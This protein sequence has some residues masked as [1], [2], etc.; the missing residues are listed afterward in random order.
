MHAAQKAVI[1]SLSD[2]TRV[3]PAAAAVDSLSGAAVVASSSSSSFVP[4][5]FA[6]DAR[7][8]KP[9]E[10]DRCLR[11]PALF[12]SGAFAL[13]LEWMAAMESSDRTDEPAPLWRLGLVIPK[14]Y[15]ASAVARNTIKRRWRDAFR[16]GRAAWATEFGSADV[17]VRL[18]APLMPKPAKAAGRGASRA[19]AVPMPPARVR[20]RDRFDA[21]AMLGGFVDRVRSRGG[22]PAHVVSSTVPS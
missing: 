9:A 14:R 13:H 22:R 2:A 18:Q 6:R 20:A 19:P 8:A 12:R 1:A 17:V 16:R 5:R 7:M 15:E 3:D 21:A 4:Q 11:K 10:F